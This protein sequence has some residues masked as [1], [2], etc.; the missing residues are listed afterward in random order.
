MDRYGLYERLSNSTDAS[1]SIER[2]DEACRAEVKRRNG[3]VVGNAFVDEGVSGA[4]PPMERPAMRRLLESLG[5]FDA[6][7]VWKI[8]RIARSFIGFAEIV[9]KLDAKGVALVSATEPIDMSGPTG[10][11]MAQM[12]AV[13]AELEREMIKARVRDS[14]RKAKE[15]ARFH[16]G[17]VP[18]GLTVADHPSG[19]G[20]VLVRDPHAVSV[21]REVL[22][23]MLEGESEGVT[24]TECARRLNLRGELTSRQR[25]AVL[26]GAKAE[27]ARWRGK[28]L[29][30]ILTSP[31][32]LGHRP[33]SGGGVETDGDGL[34]VIVWEP[35][36]SR[37]EFDALQS[38]IEG[39]RMGPRKA[40][41]AS[42][43]LSGVLR[44]NLCHRNMKQHTSADGTRSFTCRGVD[45]D[46]HKPTVYVNMV[47]VMDWIR[48][49]F[50]RVFG[51]LPEVS[52][53]W[54]PG[55]D[56]ER[57]LADVTRAIGRLRDDRD[58]G[59]FDGEE[60][61]KD[62]RERMAR[63][64]AR[65]RALADVPQVEPHWEETPTGRTYAEVWPGLTDEQRGTLLLQMEQA[66]W[67]DPAPT[68]TTP[69]GARATFGPADPVQAAL[70]ALLWEEGAGS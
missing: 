38:V 32:M 47:K 39:S 2:Q 25:G 43:W 33:V 9:S 28:A 37:D 67:V 8:D 21:L 68:R 49:E 44:C 29:E 40:P 7:M 35:V 18:Y 52:R 19:K 54:V 60:D 45:G 66:V 59:L 41:A 1:T 64:V 24:L 63:L 65:K 62:Y 5:Q 11:A 56:A 30:Q 20:R 36:F 69:V 23:W 58:V 3:R 14:M 48:E 50:P 10:R 42:H 53:V 55:T 51:H 17:R 16:G 27:P 4:L 46:T 34:P 13:F 70:D 26:K 6:V 57:E 61:E 22:L 12:I 31:T 15:D